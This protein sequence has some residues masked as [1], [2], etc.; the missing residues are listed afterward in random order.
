MVNGSKNEKITASFMYYF[1]LFLRFKVTNFHLIFVTHD[2]FD[3]M[4][5]VL[6]SKSLF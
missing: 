3:S 2:Q 1:P 4:D 6:W 5:L